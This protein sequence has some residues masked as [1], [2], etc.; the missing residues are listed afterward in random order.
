MSDERET[1]IRLRR[2]RPGEEG[3]PF[4]AVLERRCGQKQRFDRM[5]AFIQEWDHLRDHASKPGEPTIEEFAEF[6]ST[7]APTAFRMQAEFR[8]LF[9][10]ASNPGP[11]VDLLWDCMPDLATGARPKWLLA[12]EIVDLYAYDDFS[13]AANA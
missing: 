9:P 2:P 12:A 7:P 6:W 5:A 4:Y 8:S 13:P 11:L 10:P 3:Q 1:P